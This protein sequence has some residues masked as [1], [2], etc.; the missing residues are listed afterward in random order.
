MTSLWISAPAHHDPGRYTRAHHALTR[1][2][3]AP[4]RVRPSLRPR[5]EGVAGA[6][7]RPVRS[8]S[9]PQPAVRRWSRPVA[10]APMGGA[11]AVLAVLAVTVLA[12]GATEVVSQVGRAMVSSPATQLGGAP[13][14]P[15]IE[16]R[17]EAG[18]TLWSLAATLGPSGDV[19]SSLDQL[20]RLNGASGVIE[21]Q[22]VRVPEGWF[23]KAAQ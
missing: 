10:S 11:R 4:A 15:V 1:P 19:R 5:G 8:V 13:E 7:A 9:A 23:P 21:G 14:A 17:A 3:C 2:T 6:Q 22:L 18:E 20:I 12:M 16:H